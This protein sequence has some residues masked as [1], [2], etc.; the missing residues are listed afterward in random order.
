[1]GAPKGNQFWKLRSKHGRDKI[2]NS[3]ELFFNEACK[4]FEWCDKN[5]FLEIEQIKSPARAV[6]NEEGTWIFPP[7]TIALP[8]LRPYTI[9]GLCLFL[10][11]N[12]QYFNQFENSLLGKEDNISKDFS[13]IVTRIRDIIY[14]QKFS[15]AAAGF[16]NALIISRDLGLVDKKELDASVAVS[17]DRLAEI[18][19]KINA[20]AS[21]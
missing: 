8:K 20:N 6:K 18:E 1:M 17:D 16:F 2:F 13:I 12:S 11:C 19:K 9:Q 10:D 7:N 15:G 5:P 4:Y 21:S 3:P 14:N